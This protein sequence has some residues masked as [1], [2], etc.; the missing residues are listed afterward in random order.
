MQII[1]ST[2]TDPIYNL[3]LEEALLMQQKDCI[4]IWQNDNSIIVGRN[5]NIYAEVNLEAA[6]ACHTKIV[7][8]NTGGGTV[9]HDL[10]NINFSFCFSEAHFS[11]QTMLHSI[12][13]FLHACNVP[14][15][16]SGRND[17]LAENKKI[18]GCAALSRNGFTL[19][20]GTL[21]FQ[22]NTERMEQ[23][24]HI[25]PQKLKSKG[26]ASVKSRVGSIKPY[27]SP[28]WDVTHF[29]QELTAYLTAYFSA[30]T[31]EIPLE[32]VQH[33]MQE[34]YSTW[35]WN[36]G[37]NP[38]MDFSASQRFPAGEFQAELH[39]KGEHIESCRFFGDFIGMQD[40][41]LLEQKLI[42][43]PYTKDALRT[44]F[45]QEDIPAFLGEVTQEQWISLLFPFENQKNK[46]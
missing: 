37:R 32:Q 19:L 7:R 11:D 24:L 42:G 1:I 36:Y 34:K 43:T 13:S 30:E 20:H 10:Q 33:L 15:V 41:A 14:A 39:L 16:C 8:R 3:A 28:Q 25:S 21:L 23:L 35:E 18:S 27:V 6:A 31:G 5:Q 4:L 9:Y 40:V 12:L 29:M 46:S 44:F 45:R 26:I 2:Q 38:S 17:I 22:A